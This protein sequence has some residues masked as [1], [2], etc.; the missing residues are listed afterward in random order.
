[1]IF[2]IFDKIYKRRKDISSND[3][4]ELLLEAKKLSSL[5]KVVYYI[6]KTKNNY[7]LTLDIKK[8]KN[9]KDY[10]TIRPK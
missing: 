7:I 9:D 1:M 8:C 2:S 10:L 3:I 5:E 4:C 6:Y